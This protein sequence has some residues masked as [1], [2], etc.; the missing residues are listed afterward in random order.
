MNAN[1][2][3]EEKCHELE[4][5]VGE[6]NRSLWK[7]GVSGDPA[8]EEEAAL[9]ELADQLEGEA[10]ALPVRKTVKLLA[11]I[12]LHVT[13]ARLRAFVALAAQLSEHERQ[14]LT[15][16][17]RLPEEER[18]TIATLLRLSDTDR[19]ELAVVLGLTK[20]E[21]QALAALVGDVAHRPG[22]EIV[23]PSDCPAEGDEQRG[24]LVRPMPD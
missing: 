14:N 6:L 23:A 5:L 15:A 7:Q 21:C 1:A 12:V 20:A 24:R 4:T 17:L 9:P 11:G 13:L 3:F 19:R 16:L 10:P 8:S 18:R 2:A 22:E